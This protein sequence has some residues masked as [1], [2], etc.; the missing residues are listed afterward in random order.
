MTNSILRPKGTW[1]VP[2]TYETQTDPS[3]PG[4]KFKISDGANVGNYI[5]WMDFLHPYVKSAQLYVCPSA[6]SAAEASYGY[7]EV[8]HQQ[9]SNPA[10]PALA[11]AELERPSKGI[12]AMDYNTIYGLY[13]NPLE[14]GV[15]ATTPASVFHSRVIVHL[16]GANFLFCDGH[17][18][19][20]DQK[21]AA[22]TSP[23]NSTNRLWNPTIA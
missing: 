23:M 11:L 6:P 13:A 19:W 5:G 1:N 14:Y 12:L 7:N 16:E 9:R 2:A 10:R 20:F 22:T 15:W 18:K 4:S 21:N 3:M 17:V 8:I